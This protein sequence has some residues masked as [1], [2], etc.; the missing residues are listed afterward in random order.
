MD[1]VDRVVAAEP[2]TWGTADSYN[3]THPF[4]AID[5]LS[6]AITS[7]ARYTPVR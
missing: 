3:A 1:E 5:E 7:G 6:I 2:A 4:N